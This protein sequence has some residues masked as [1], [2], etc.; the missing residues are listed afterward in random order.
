MKFILSIVIFCLLSQLL[1]CNNSN[2]AVLNLHQD[3]QRASFVKRPFDDSIAAVTSLKSWQPMTTRD[4]QAPITEKTALWLRFNMDDQQASDLYIATFHCAYLTEIYQG[5]QLVRS[6][7]SAKRNGIEKFGPKDYFNITKLDRSAQKNSIF[8]KILLDPA[9]QNSGFCMATYLGNLA[10]VT[11]LYAVFDLH[12]IVCGFAVTVIGLILVIF[13]LKFRSS[14][15]LNF[16]MF[17]IFFGTGYITGS[18]F[19]TSITNGYFHNWN[20]WEISLALFSCF[21]IFFFRNMTP[22]G[23]RLLG[24]LASLNLLFLLLITLITVFDLGLQIRSI[25]FYLFILLGLEIA[26]MMVCAVVSG[27]KSSGYDRII[28]FGV[29]LLLFLFVSDLLFLFELTTNPL[30]GSFGVLFTIALLAINICLR[31]LNRLARLE[32]KNLGELRVNQERLESE[33]KR[34]TMEL[35]S[36]AE[37]VSSANQELEDSNVLL[38]ATNHQ[39][40]SFHARTTQI[41]NRLNEIELSNIRALKRLFKS[42]EMNPELAAAGLREI[43]NL[44]QDF[45]PLTSN[46]L[47]AKSI[48]D[49][50]VLHLSANRKDLKFTKIALGGTLIKLVQAKTAQ[51]CLSILEKQRFDLLIIDPEFSHIAK[52]CN[53][54]FYHIKI[55]L[56]TSDQFVLHIDQLLAQDFIPNLIFKDEK[57]PAFNLRNLV[58]TATTLINAD[59]FGISKYLA[60]GA[61]IQEIPVTSSQTRAEI[62]DQMAIF[63]K[64]AGVRRSSINKAVLVCDEMLMNIIYDAPTDSTGRPKYNH[65]PRTEA[66]ALSPSEQGSLR[67]GFDGNTIAIAGQDPFGA[68]T[69]ETILKYVRSCYQGKYGTINQEL[70]KAGGGM[71]IFQILS[72]SDLVVVNVKEGEKTEFVSL[73]NV[74]SHVKT[75]RHTTSFQ[76]FK[77]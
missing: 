64:E 27:V 11:N 26:V 40:H 16:G 50:T 7:N 62:I 6:F 75:D 43:R 8:Y 71:G 32:E 37:Q 67:F 38:K 15:L 3:E 76:F 14:L 51:E 60:W 53:E 12:V 19:F 57:D 24:F 68:L 17:C 65:L 74:L 31:Y 28:R 33:V 22:Y 73:I 61:N 42:P 39:L 55:I 45:E 35:A 47:S 41:L 44:E 77:I 20:L 63:L 36:K 69:R 49:R 13:F 1:G 5:E 48:E 30:L 59:Y 25:R 2:P 56:M 29:L 58:T 18:N 52:V 23:Y 9:L 70:G 46:Y 10:A 54:R 4:R 34:R 72:S 21:F 66:V